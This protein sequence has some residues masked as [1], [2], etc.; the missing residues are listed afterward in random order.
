M[1]TQWTA[2]TSTTCYLKRFA[3]WKRNLHF[4]ATEMTLI[5]YSLKIPFFL[6][7]VHFL[8]LSWWVESIRIWPQKSFISQFVHLLFYLLMQRAGQC[9]A[10]IKG[11][12]FYALN[13]SSERQW[14]SGIWWEWRR[15]LILVGYQITHVYKINKSANRKQRF[16]LIGIINWVD[17]LQRSNVTVWHF[18][19]LISS[20]DVVISFT[21]SHNLPHSLFLRRGEWTLTITITNGIYLYNKPF[22]TLIV[23]LNTIQQ[24]WTEQRV[25]VREERGEGEKKEWNQQNETFELSKMSLQLCFCSL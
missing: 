8:R 14:M 20:D 3:S 5:S 19:L 11:G 21:L 22:R 6:V 9:L 10:N 25:R 24:Q 1:A 17:G 12:D 7:F 18:C 15:H 16:C 13:V 4:L 2:L 23:C